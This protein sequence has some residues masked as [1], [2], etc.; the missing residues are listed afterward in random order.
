MNTPI[1]F[2]LAKLLVDKGIEIKS[3]KRYFLNKN[4]EEITDEFIF[5]KYK[6]KVLNASIDAAKSVYAISHISAPTI[7][8][9]VMWLY[10]KHKIWIGVELTDNTRDFYFQPK[11]WTSK[12]RE[13]HDEDMTDQAK[14]ISDWKEWRFN[15]PAESYKAAIEYCLTKII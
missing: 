13:Y 10:E 8:E 3:N 14:Y 12:D 2:E 4:D 6:G 9:V 1:K 11:I 5:E 15:T 7:A